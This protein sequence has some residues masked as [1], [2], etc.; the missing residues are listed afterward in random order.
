MTKLF[1]AARCLS[2]IALACTALAGCAGDDGGDAAPPIAAPA[3]PDAHVVVGSYVAHMHPRQSRIDLARIR[4]EI[5]GAHGDQ[6]TPEGLTNASIVSN[7]VA[8]SGPNN[9]VELDTLS[10]KDTYMAA[11]SGSC[12]A[13]AFCGDVTF[14]HFF[15]GLN[16][17]AVYAQIT[18]ISGAGGVILHNHN[19]VNGVASNP[20]GLDLTYG[21]WSY[22]ASMATLGSG[23][24]ATKTWAFANP[25]DSDFDV[26]IDVY[27]ALYPMLWFDT[28][29]NGGITQ[30]APLVAGQ[31]AIVHYM[32]A[33]NKSC[34]GASWSMQGYLK[35]FN[36]DVHTT[37]WSGV[38]TDTFFDQQVIMPFSSGV[39]LWFNN[40]DSGCNIYDSNGG[41]NFN[42]GI[43]N[44]SPTLHFTG[45]NASV[46]PYSTGN[47]QWFSD[48]SL[49]GG[50]T[51]S[52]DYELDRVVCG[53]LDRYGRVPAGT[54]ATMYTSFDNGP[55]DAGVSLLGLPYDVPGA[56]NGASGRV[57]VP[58]QI[59]I[60]AGSHKTSIYF[61]ST[62]G[63][64]CHKY[65]SG[66]S[67]FN[68]S[69]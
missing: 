48:S 15:P 40:T 19:A 24:G 22:T 20:F 11:A 62:D 21:A 17:S 10:T 6:L 64:G 36:I 30:T 2:S 50:M 55:F 63:S 68:F 54:T 7:S 39:D 29:A 41:S 12:P 65:D 23:T 5:A 14:T 45:P 51:V 69:Y 43:S 9:T 53:S 26:Y 16:L 8:G 44:V 28:A 56:I 52:V 37:S 27:A 25:D 66:G 3:G 35:G 60:P 67:N 4:K 31:P 38:S 34:R 46:S 47:W 33:R 58:P 61:D 18:G 59:N 42:F 13:G 57:Y 1:A 49:H 32:Y